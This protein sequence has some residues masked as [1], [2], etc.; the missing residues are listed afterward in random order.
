M[1]GVGILAFI[2]FLSTLVGVPVLPRLSEE[3]GAD[4]AEIPIV[5]SAALATLVVAQFFTGA[6]ADRYSKRRLMMVGALLGSASSFLCAVATDWGQLAAL[7]VIGGIADAITMPALLSITASLGADRPGRFFGILRSSQALSF[8]VGPALGSAFSLISL[9]MPFIADGALSLLAF[10]A[11]AALLKGTD[12]AGSDH[13]LGVFRGIRATF[14]D[15]RVYLY[16]LMGFSGLF[17][18]GI[19]YSFVPTK[20]T[21]IGL[22]AWEIGVVLAAGSLAFGLVSYAVGVLSDRFG[23]RGF[24]VVAQGII[25]AA[26]VGLIFSSSFAAVCVFYVLFCAGEATTYLLAFVYAS[27]VFEEKHMGASMGV[28]DAILDLSL[29]IGPLI[30]ISVYASTGQ[31]PLVFLIAGAPAVLAFFA[32]AIYLPARTPTGRV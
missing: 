9:R 21:L 6:L 2:L 24:V 8:V 20:A 16:L 17:A 7:R 3:L 19:L 28:F 29:L 15:A 4:A 31:M 22:E 1:Y 25:I 23:R 5:V 12:R 27:A 14:A 18:F 32:A 30:A 10:F 26:G 13:H 11:I